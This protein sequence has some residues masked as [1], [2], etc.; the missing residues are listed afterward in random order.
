MREDRLLGVYVEGV[1]EYVVTT[2]GDCFTLL[3]RGERNRI[4]RQTR[5]NIKS[6]RSH[7]MFQ[8]VLEVSSPDGSG[9]LTRAKLN[10]CDLAGSEKIHAEEQLG[11]EHLQELKTINLSLSTL[12]KVISALAKPKGTTPAAA[13]LVPYRESKLTRLL[14][15]SL[16]VHTR[17]ILIATLSPLTE[18]IEESV[19]TLKFAD[20]AKQVMVRVTANEVNAKDDAVVQKL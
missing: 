18:C 3:R 14:K 15:D 17:T 20:R 8:I 13:A 19:S 12:G 6:S 7:T 5:S 4:T 2:A 10:L 11:A 16:G 9:R 1:S